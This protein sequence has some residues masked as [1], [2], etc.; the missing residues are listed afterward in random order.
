MG[1]N[2]RETWF[3]DDKSHLAYVILCRK[4]SVKTQLSIRPR[5]QKQPLGFDLFALPLIYFIVV[6]VVLF[7]VFHKYVL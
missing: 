4:T 2:D 7:V 1:R 3:I 6:V 5:G